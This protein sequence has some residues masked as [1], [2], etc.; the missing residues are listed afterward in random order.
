MYATA[1]LL[2]K[3]K[4]MRQS[5]RWFNSDSALYW[6]GQPQKVNA[7]HSVRVPLHSTVTKQAQ[8]NNFEYDKRGYP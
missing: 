6:L 4:V 5:L 7:V 3:L 8:P 2:F 1:A